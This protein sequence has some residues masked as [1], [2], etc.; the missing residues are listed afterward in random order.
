MIIILKKSQLWNGC[1]RLK[2]A[3]L[4]ICE[5]KSLELDDTL[6]KE[7]VRGVKD[8]LQIFSVW[9]NYSLARETLVKEWVWF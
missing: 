9:Q 1:Y 8:D 5:V 2:I 7:C 3:N 4:D 6:H